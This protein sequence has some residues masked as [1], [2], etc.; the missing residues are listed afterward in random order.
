MVYNRLVLCAIIALFANGVVGVEPFCK[1]A[2]DVC[3]SCTQDSSVMDKLNE[4]SSDLEEAKATIAKMEAREG[5]CDVKHDDKCF[6]IISLTYGISYDQAK[7]LCAARGGSA[8]NIYS[9]D[10]YKKLMDYLFTKITP[11]KDKTFVWIGMF[12][13]PTRMGLYLSD[14]LPAPFAHWVDGHPLT[15]KT[16]TRLALIQ[17]VK[18]DGTEPIG[19]R[20]MDVSDM[21]RLGVICEY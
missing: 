6:S 14:G 5:L 17:N 10:Q 4:M 13:D 19:M 2:C 12:F 8:A 18:Q 20:T 11:G 21:T 1:E 15:D 7:R 16:H 9:A 3:Q